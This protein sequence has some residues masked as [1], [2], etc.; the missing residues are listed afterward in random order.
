M[1]GQR[2][3]QGNGDRTISE[4]SILVEI[5]FNLGGRPLHT[6][7]GTKNKLVGV[8]PVWRRQSGDVA[9]RRQGQTFSRPGNF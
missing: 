1:C 7:P 9:A 8:A 6:A 2:M 5:G 4:A 3:Q